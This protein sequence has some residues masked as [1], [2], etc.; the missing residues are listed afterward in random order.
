LSASGQSQS[1]EGTVCISVG[2]I[3]A[4][5]ALPPIIEKL[6]TQQPGIEIEIVACNG[7][8]DLRRREADIAFRGGELTQPDLIA[9]KGW[10]FNE[11][12]LCLT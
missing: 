12:L 3:F 5:R 9:E 7:S 6:R 1:I 11:P 4:G 10:R 8:S 2:E